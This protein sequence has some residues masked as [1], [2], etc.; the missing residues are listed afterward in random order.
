MSEFHIAE[1]LKRLRTFHGYRQQDISEKLNISRQAYSNYERGTR[2][3]DL[4]TASKLA[5]FY[6]IPLDRLAHAKD[7]AG[8]IAESDSHLHLALTPVGSTIRMNGPDAKMF[9]SYKQLSEPLQ[10][11]VRAFVKFKKTQ[12][13]LED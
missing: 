3:P 9:L 10:K 2:L 1:N 5:R 11:E 6:N 4:E 8:I 12:Q 13:E 7:P